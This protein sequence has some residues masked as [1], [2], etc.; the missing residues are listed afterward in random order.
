MDYNEADTQVIIVEMPV[1]D[2]LYYFFDNGKTDYNRFVVNV[3]EL[4]NRYEVPFW[5]TEP[6][7][8]IPDD[9]WSD[10]SHLNVTGAEIFSTWLGQ[11]VGKLDIPNNR[12]S[13]QP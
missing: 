2:G 10:Y 7:D 12:D 11:Q 13:P 6:L 5:Q 3:R 1:S 9:G 4:A 8:S